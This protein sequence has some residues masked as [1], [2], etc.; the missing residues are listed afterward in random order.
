VPDQTAL[1]QELTHFKE[2]TRSAIRGGNRLRDMLQ[3]ATGFQW[4]A[5]DG[6]TVRIQPIGEMWAVYVAGAFECTKDRADAAIDAAARIAPPADEELARAITWT[7]CGRPR[8]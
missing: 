5:A 6:A 1:Q 8:A 3:L 2:R 4:T 7:A